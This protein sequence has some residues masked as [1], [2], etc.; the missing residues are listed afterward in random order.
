MVPSDCTLLVV[1]NLFSINDKAN[2]SPTQNAKSKKKGHR[3]CVCLSVSGM[4]LSVCQSV[5]DIWDLSVSEFLFSCLGAFRG[6]RE[7]AIHDAWDLVGTRA[8]AEEENRGQRGASR[9]PSMAAG[10]LEVDAR[11]S[12]ESYLFIYLFI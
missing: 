6:A 4:C 11:L 2:V 1:Y 7:P 3:V 8:A 12:L 5:G 9:R 10:S